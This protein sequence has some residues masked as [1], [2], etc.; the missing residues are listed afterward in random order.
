M[1]DRRLR[2]NPDE[3]GVVRLAAFRIGGIGGAG[4]QVKPFQWNSEQATV[5]RG[6]ER[7]AF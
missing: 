2:F 7:R 4:E 6:R 1:R 5:A 3:T